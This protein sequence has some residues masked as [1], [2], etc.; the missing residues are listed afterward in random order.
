MARFSVTRWIEGLNTRINKLRLGEAEAVVADDVDLSG[1]ELRPEKGLNTGSTAAGDYRFKGTWV[2]KSDGKKFIEAGDSLIISLSSALATFVRRWYNT[3]GQLQSTLVQE[4]SIGVPIKPGTAPQV[5][6]NTSGSTSSGTVKAQSNIYT[7]SFGAAIHN[8]TTDEGRY[9]DIAEQATKRDGTVFY[10]SGTTL[11]SF[12]PSTG[13]VK[14]INI[15]TGAVTVSDVQ[16]THKSKY[17]IHNGKL[18]G[19]DADYENI[20]AMDIISSSAAYTSTIADPTVPTFDASDYEA[21]FSAQT[22]RSKSHTLA[23]DKLIITKNYQYTSWKDIQNSVRGDKNTASTTPTNYSSATDF[24]D[25][26]TFG[27]IKGS[28]DSAGRVLLLI[29]PTAAVNENSNIGIRVGT[30]FDNDDLS[31]G[32]TDTNYGNGHQTRSS[33]YASPPGN[34]SNYSYPYTSQ[35]YGK[36]KDITINSVGYRAALIWRV[37]WYAESM[38][39]QHGINVHYEGYNNQTPHY[40]GPQILFTPFHTWGW[41]GFETG[42]TAGAAST[43]GFVLHWMAQNDNGSYVASTDTQNLVSLDNEDTTLEAQIAVSGSSLVIQVRD[44]VS[45]SATYEVS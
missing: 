32:N 13:Y 14:R 40:A 19:I 38:V 21:G 15:T 29:Y 4:Q 33:P 17:F 16:L 5:S 36:Y 10:S 25:A 12:N 7:E 24:T 41:S 8:A 35:W 30:S 42:T 23:E 44:T 37:D 9:A 3:S 22:L 2:T 45:S 26:G 1:L 34:P 11:A 27:H 18:V 43:V 6:L 31:T 20:Q 28:N 39:Y